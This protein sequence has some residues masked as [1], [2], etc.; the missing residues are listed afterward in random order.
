MDDKED[1]QRLLDVSLK[2][3]SIRPRSEKELRTFLIQKVKKWKITNETVI[4]QVIS[5]L[6]EL[7]YVNDYKFTQWWIDISYKTRHK[8]E[9][10]VKAELFQKG[11]SRDII[12]ELINKPENRESS[13]PAPIHQLMYKKLSLLKAE[14]PIRRKHKL[15]QYLIGRGYNSD[16]VKKIIDAELSKS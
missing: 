14:P 5:R 9:R 10:I 13:D 12:E 11:V 3:V 1:Y 8:G 6:S 16:T 2:L 4:E 7:D 15:F